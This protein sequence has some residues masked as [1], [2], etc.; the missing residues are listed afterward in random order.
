M[1]RKRRLVRALRL[2]LRKIKKERRKIKEQFFFFFSFRGYV[3]DC[4]W[5][6]RGDTCIVLVVQCAYLNA[7]ERVLKKGGGGG[8]T[9]LPWKCSPRDAD[10]DFFILFLSC[11]LGHGRDCSLSKNSSLTLV[12][13]LI[14]VAVSSA[15]SVQSSGTHTHTQNKLKESEGGHECSFMNGGLGVKRESKRKWKKW[16]HVENAPSSAK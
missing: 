5:L 15:G 10:L 2:R 1:A 16:D 9:N 7:R 13:L 6:P 11:F 3:L 12:Y 14:D 4:L 8:A